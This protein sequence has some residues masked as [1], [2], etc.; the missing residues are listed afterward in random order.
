MYLAAELGDFIVP[1]FDDEDY[2]LFL[3]AMEKAKVKYYAK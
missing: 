3:D 1:M 2:E